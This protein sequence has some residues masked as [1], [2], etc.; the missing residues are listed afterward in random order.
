[1]LFGMPCLL[2]PGMMSG[3]YLVPAAPRKAVHAPIP[4]CPTPCKFTDGEVWS[5]IPRDL[6]PESEM[7]CL[8]YL[9]WRGISCPLSQHTNTTFSFHPSS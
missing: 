5:R 9:T 2:E 6:H 4:C 1:M 3:R 8:D 7:E